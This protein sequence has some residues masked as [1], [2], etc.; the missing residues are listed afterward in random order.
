MKTI[1]IP[2]KQL[3]LLAALPI[4][5]L[6]VLADQAWKGTTDNLWTTPGNWSGGVPGSGDVVIYNNLSTANLSNWLGQPFGISGILVSNVPAAF[7]INDTDP[8]TDPLTITPISPA[9]NG[10]DMTKATHSLTISAGVVLGANQIWNVTNTQTLLVPGV[11]SGSGGLYKDGFG[12]LYLTATNGFTGSF[13]NNGGP[14]WIDNSAALGSGAKTIYIANNLVGAGLHLNGTNGSI[15][16]PGTSTFI[17]SQNL[18]AVFNE[19]GDNAI[20]G[21]MFVF[22]GGGFAYVLANAG[23]LTL[24]GTIGLSTSARPFQVGGAANGIIN[25]PVTSTL[26]LTKTDSGTWT[27]NHTNNTYSGVTT[28]QGGTLVLGPAARIPNT[29][30][31]MLVSNATLDVSAMT[32]NFANDNAFYLTPAS[33]VQAL[34]GSGTVNGNVLCANT[35]YIVPGGSNAV[36]TLTVTTNLILNGGVVVPVELNTATTPGGGVND[37][38]NVGGL[39]D[40]QFAM[41]SVTPLGLLTS[42]ATYRLVNYGTESPNPFS[43]FVAT[44]SRCTFTLTDSATSPGHIDLTVTGGNSNLVWSGGNGATWDVNNSANWTGDTQTFF[45]SD[46]VTFDDSSANNTVT[47]SGATGAVRPVSVTVSNN[48]AAYLFQGPGKITGLTGLTKAGAGTLVI[49]NTASDYTGP[50]VVNGGTLSV[51]A[52]ANGGTAS[53]LGAGTSVT[54]N[55]GTFLFSGPRPAA[56]GFNRTWVLGANGG[57][58]LSTNG[59]FFMQ[60]Q[61]SGP[62]SLTKTGTVQIIL[63]DIVTGVLSAGASNSYSGNTFVTQGE[64]QI[65]NNHALGFGK[66]VVSNNADLSFGGGVNY[67]TLT[68]NIDL[69]GGD[70]NGSAGALQVNDANTVVTYSGTINLLSSSGVGSFT[71]PSS[72]TISGPIIGPGGLRKKNKV[73]CTVILTS[74]ASSY[75]GGTLVEAG[76]LQLGSGTTCGSLGSGPVTNNGTLAYNH[77]DTITNASAISGTG[78]LT[79]TGAGILALNG[80]NTYSGTTAVN[81]GTVAVNGALGANTVTVANNATLSGYGA[82]GGAVTVNSGGTLALGAS[83][84][85]LSINNT[86]NLAGT[87]VMKINK[88]GSTLTCDLIQGMTTL[89]YGGVLKVTATGNALGAGDSFKLFNA[90]TYASNFSSTNLPALSGGLFWDTTGLTNNGTIKVTSPNPVISSF[91]VLGNGNFQLTFSGSAGANYRIWA[92]TNVAFRPVT[93]TWSNLISGT[94]GSGSATYTDPQASLYSRRFYVITSP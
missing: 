27:L 74:P 76:T 46:A 65:R 7:S 67:G 77:S 51:N 52:V 5:A 71:A 22:S 45:N 23:S 47:I 61:I 55:G 14:V 57:T 88:T 59:V 93:S 50:V 8:I 2:F 92:S 73:T 66:A 56:S 18:G 16:I 83:I 42:G 86:L 54:L 62:G 35:A 78:N 84:G 81:G 17:V 12:S 19:A 34:G 58:V 10:I 28:I 48:N 63:G 20:D 37:L 38:L 26:P 87:N 15:V 9:T 24:N 4:L 75:S 29:P 11:V 91:K 90:T 85:T 44:D 25:G 36:G 64:L 49:S 40:P 80:I 70:G 1:V 3:V 33:T 30:S 89:T 13:T 6:P 43:S 21:G 94:F 41:I 31:I 79:H 69:N 72:F 82:I 39:L 32:N 60:N 53:E 68:N